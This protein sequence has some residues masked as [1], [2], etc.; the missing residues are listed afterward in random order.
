MGIKAGRWLLHCIN[1]ELVFGLIGGSTRLLVVVATSSRVH[2][3][4]TLGGA[5]RL[6]ATWSARREG[7]SDEAPE[8]PCSARCLFLLLHLLLGGAVTISRRTVVSSRILALGCDPRCWAVPC[9][10]PP[11]CFSLDIGCPGSA[12]PCNTCEYLLSLSKD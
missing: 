7:L 4:P 1:S 11:C 10:S 6:P 9:H 5:T 8:V 2:D 12:P 3:S